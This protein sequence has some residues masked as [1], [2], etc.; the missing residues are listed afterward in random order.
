RLGRG[1]FAV[2]SAADARALHRRSCDEAYFIGPAEPRESYLCIERLIE[3]A[4]KSGAECVHPGYGFLSESGDFAEACERAGIVFIGP[5][6][7][8]I[9]AMGLKDRAKVLMQKAGVRI[10][11]GYHGERQDAQFLKERANEIGYPVLI[12]PAAGGGGRGLRRIDKESDFKA[13]LEGAVREVATAFGS[14]RVLVE[15]FV[16][17]PR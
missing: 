9:R 16:A 17:A 1:G 8:A 5:P 10:V 2:Y 3:A 6:A 13:E 15:K 7:A 11:P 14:G 12:K 4:K